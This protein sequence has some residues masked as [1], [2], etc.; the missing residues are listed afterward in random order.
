[1]NKRV[2]L[3]MSGGVDS[4]VSAL[5]LKD[6]GYDV[7]GVYMKNWSEDLP[8]MKCPWAEDLADAKR[9]AVQLDLDF[10]VWDFEKDY[11]AKVVDYML[12][13][14]KKG[15]TPN[16]DV[17]C[18]ELIK[19]KLFYDWALERDAD[20]IATG[21][22]ART[23]QFNKVGEVIFEGIRSHGEDERGDPATAGVDDAPRKNASPTASDLLKAV[24]A[25][26][27]QTYFLYRMSDAATAK[28]LFPIGAMDKP[29]VKKLAAERGLD[30]A[31]KKE[32][33]GICFVGEVGMKDFLARYIDAQPGEIREQETGQVL[34]Y[35]DGAIFYTIGQR[36]GLY[37][38]GG[39]PYYVVAKDLDQNFVFVSKNLNHPNLWTTKLTLE[40]LHL[41]SGR[42]L[43]DLANLPSSVAQS[44]SDDAP[45]PVN[46]LGLNSL[47][48]DPH[49]LQVRLRHRA[50]LIDCQIDPKSATLHFAQPIKRPAPGQSA[51]LYSGDIC[52]GGG[53]IAE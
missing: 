11:K 10:E 19:F 35:H 45:A 6:Q 20:F 7:T 13:E 25:N 33:M 44:S 14:F 18:N 46:T 39:L 53:I 36:H 5:L 47:T 48:P 42:T 12:A 22:Y 4:S 2:Y 31:T 29:A 28:T 27:D 15:R 26:K 49:R 9:V 38:G 34:G 23:S 1:M 3:G 17:M 30:V 32:S 52:L 37:L 24:D 41:R 8:G 51:V 50:P 43:A 21:H 16:P 40:N